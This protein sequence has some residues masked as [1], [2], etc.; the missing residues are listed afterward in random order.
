MAAESR[1]PAKITRYIMDL[2][3]DF[4]SFYNSCHVKGDD[5]ELMAARLK[6]VDSVRIVMAGILGMLKITAPEK[7]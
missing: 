6:L 4:H 5:N 3:T 2:A 7:M 1:E